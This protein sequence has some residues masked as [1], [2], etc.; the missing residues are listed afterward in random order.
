LCGCSKHSIDSHCPSFVW[1]TQCRTGNELIFVR[2]P[3]HEAGKPNNFLN[4]VNF[5]VAASGVQTFANFLEMANRVALVEIFSTT[6][7]ERWKND[8]YWV[9]EARY[10]K[11]HGITVDCGGNVRVLDLSNNDLE[12]LIPEQRFCEVL[13]NLQCLYLQS[14]MLTGHIPKNIGSLVSLVELN[15]SWNKLEGIF[16]FPVSY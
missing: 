14:N 8:M 2:L 6:A 11:W 13:L 12:G 4:P 16:R 9:T 10:H 3:F 15:L 7:G 1:Q 5:T